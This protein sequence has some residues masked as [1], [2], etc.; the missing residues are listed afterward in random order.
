MPLATS[1]SPIIFVVLVVAALAVLAAVVIRARAGSKPTGD[2]TSYDFRVG[3]RPYFFTRPENAFYTALAPIAQE[4]GLCVFPKVGLNDVFQDKPG[5]D[6][7]QYNRYAQMHVDY[8]LVTRQD[9]RPVA[10]IEL[11][12]TSHE[13]ERQRTR[14]MKKSAVF[15]AAKLPLI[16]FN[17]GAHEREIQ[18]QLKV[19]LGRENALAASTSSR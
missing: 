7:G 19:T 11:N 3:P 15:S 14:D 5:A 8:L 4:L 16:Q 10:G 17:N 13:R 2:T 1:I 6:R 12:G 18:H 9:Y